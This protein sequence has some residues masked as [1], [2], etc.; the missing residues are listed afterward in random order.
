MSF[1]DPLV[2]LVTPPGAG[3]QWDEKGDHSKSYELLNCAQVSSPHTLP[4]EQA[5][6]HFWLVLSDEEGLRLSFS[7]LLLFSLLRL[8]LP[9]YCRLGRQGTPYPRAYPCARQMPEGG[10]P[11]LHRAGSE[12][13]PRPGEA[14]S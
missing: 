10:L 12:T 14:N 13:A 2:I 3:N 1:T 4:S 9:I 11:C 8:Q 5:L 7:W 6:T